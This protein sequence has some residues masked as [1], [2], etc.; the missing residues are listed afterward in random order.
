MDGYAM[1]N[2]ATNVVEN[3]IAWDGVSPYSPPD[4]YILVKVEDP[5]VTTS[6]LYVDGQF[7]SPITEPQPLVEGGPVLLA[8]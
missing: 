6:W 4:G 8:E 3:L 1:I 2:V 5:Q 7:V